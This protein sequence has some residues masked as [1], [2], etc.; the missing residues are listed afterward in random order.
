MAR[1]LHAHRRRVGDAGGFDVHRRLDRRRPDP[2]ENE[3]GFRV[4]VTPTVVHF[5]AI[6]IACLIV[7]APFA[8]V[9]A[10]G[11][12]LLAEGAFGLAYCGW[13][14]WRA[15]KGGYAGRVDHID[16]IWYALAPV[17][18]Y[19]VVAGAAIA[20]VA[21]HGTSLGALACGLGLLLIAAVR[22]AWDMTLWIMM[23][24]R[25]ET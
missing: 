25:G 3:A 9:T 4:F 7:L 18:G 14:W 19:A 24:P 20:M 15:R 8:S 11:A 23:R 12:V 5:S 16:R 2:R 22:N 21:G 1:F 6:L 13:M 17:V 10:L